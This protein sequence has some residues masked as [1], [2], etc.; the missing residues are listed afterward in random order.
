MSQP[1]KI[2]RALDRLLETH[3]SADVISVDWQTD[4]DLY[5]YS[6]PQRRWTSEL[7]GPWVLVKLADRLDTDPPGWGVVK[8]AIWKHTGDVYI[9]GADGAVPDDPLLTL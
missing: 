8:F 1:S 6:V 3:P 5:S 2:R 7:V 9:V 4:D